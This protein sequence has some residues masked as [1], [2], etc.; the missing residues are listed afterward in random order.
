ME[1]S[2]WVEFFNNNDIPKPYQMCGYVKEGSTNILCQC[3]INR[4]SVLKLI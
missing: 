3:F 4:V 2:N 1:T